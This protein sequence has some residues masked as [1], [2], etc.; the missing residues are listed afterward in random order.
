MTLKALVQPNGR[1]AQ[2]EP[3]GEDFPV[4]EP[5]EWV[6]APDDTTTR[7]TWDG[8]NVV[9]FIP[10]PPLTTDA[11]LRTKTLSLAFIVTKLVD[12]LIAN[13]TIQVAD[14]DVDTRQEYIDMKALVDSI[15]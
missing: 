9:K 7:D 15:R 6:D 3:L 14:F 4:A 10:L 8:A 5:L 2:I 12:Q 1:I 11:V 13:G